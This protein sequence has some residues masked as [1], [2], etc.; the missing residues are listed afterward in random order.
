MGVQERKL[1]LP[2]RN[3]RRSVI[4]SRSGSSASSGASRPVSWPMLEVYADQILR[5]F[6][7]SV[8]WEIYWFQQP[9]GVDSG[10]SS[11]F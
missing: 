6:G 7:G 9:D 3:I 2:A 5:K 4:R 8:A 11:F 10:D 1:A